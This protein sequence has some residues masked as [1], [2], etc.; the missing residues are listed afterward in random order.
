MLFA[1]GKAY[2][3]NKDFNLSF[4][5]YKEGNWLQRK[6]LDYNAQ[7]NSESIDNIISFFM[8]NN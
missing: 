7:E 5:Y 3:T 8:S 6:T 2:E 4:K 1:L